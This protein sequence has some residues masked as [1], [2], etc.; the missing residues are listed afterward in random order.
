MNACPKVSIVSPSFN[1][2]QFIEETI[3][4]VLNQKYPNIEYIII[5]GGSTDGSVD[6][7]RKY[8]KNISYWI[9]EKDEGQTDAI[10]KGLSLATGS[11]LAYLNTDDVYLPSTVETVVRFFME[12][13]NV[14]MVYGDIF[15]MDERSHIGKRINPNNIDFY[16]L[17]SGRFYLPQPT[18]FFRKEVLDD[19]GYFDKNLNLAMDL[20]YWIR[21]YLNQYNI[22]YINEVL[23]KVRIYPNAKS[24]SLK[25]KYL[26][27]K[28]QILS[29]VFSNSSISTEIIKRKKQVYG[30]VYLESALNYIKIFYF[31]EAFKCFFTAF[32][33]Y[34]KCYFIILSAACRKVKSSLT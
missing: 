24:I 30:E 16:K 18:V 6:I 21:M 23:A 15:Q 17:L 1:Q 22:T 31:K 5:D 9:S 14:F 33:L 2:V 8:E 26:G 12:N 7:I 32:L 19:I 11:I 3:C 34:P 25:H 13:P 29:K 20:D 10:N 4:S 28:L 27:E